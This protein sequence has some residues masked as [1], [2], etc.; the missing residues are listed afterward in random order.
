MNDNLP[1]SHQQNLRLAILAAGEGSRLRAEGIEASKPL[2]KVGGQTLIERIVGA[3]VRSGVRSACC[4]INEESPDLR[5]YLAAHDFGIEIRLLVQSTPSSMHSLFALSPWLLDGP[6]CLTTVDSV[7]HEE[8][9]RAFLA[10][11]TSAGTADGTLAV[12][13]FID[14]EKPL[15]VAMEADGRI[16]RFSDSREGYTWAT[17][18]LYYFT[19]RIFDHREKA[20][21]RRIERLRNFLRLLLEQGCRLEGYALTKIIDVDHVHDIAVAEEFL[22]ASRARPVARV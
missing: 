21:Q 5:E 15:C 12:T 18:G 20:M 6:F 7:F 14:D 11:A 3:A 4:I 8:E 13:R 17:G 9:F 2:V 19:P 22:S 10:H 16:A 1:T